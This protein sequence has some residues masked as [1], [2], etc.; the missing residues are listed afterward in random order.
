MKHLATSLVF[1][2]APGR[3]LE[4]AAPARHHRL[5][6]AHRM[7]RFLAAVRE[8]GEMGHLARWR[9]RPTAG[10]ENEGTGQ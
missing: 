5:A 4:P 6:Q 2:P 10:D 8:G 9:I 3:G 7:Q 1:S